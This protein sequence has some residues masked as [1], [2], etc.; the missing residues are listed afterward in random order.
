MSTTKSLLSYYVLFEY[1]TKHQYEWYLVENGLTY[2]NN[3]Y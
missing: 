3:F 1:T 2:V